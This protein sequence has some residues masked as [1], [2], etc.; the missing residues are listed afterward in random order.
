M[1]TDEGGATPGVDALGAAR[2]RP[3]P[4]GGGRSPLVRRLSGAQRV[5]WPLAIHLMNIGVIEIRGASVGASAGAT[6]GATVLLER[7]PLLEFTSPFGWLRESGTRLLIP[8]RGGRRG[9]LERRP[10]LRS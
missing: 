2:A 7:W 6:A 1:H 9:Q 4:W 8:H 10:T 5:R 3:G